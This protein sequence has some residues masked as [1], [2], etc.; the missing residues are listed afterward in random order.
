[1][2]ASQRPLLS[3]SIE[4]FLVV[5]VILMWGAPSAFS[6]SNPCEGFAPTN[7]KN[8]SLEKKI[9]VSEV[10]RECERKLAQKFKDSSAKGVESPRRD[11]RTLAYVNAGPNR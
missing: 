9:Q 1:M 4:L 7:F 10:I 5:S 11:T 3:I 2:T 6:A 8:L